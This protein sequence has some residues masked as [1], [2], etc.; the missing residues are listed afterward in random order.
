MFFVLSLLSLP[1]LFIYDNGTG[2]AKNNILRDSLFGNH[3]LGNLGQNSMQCA[4]GH[5]GGPENNIVLNLE[6]PYGNI[7]KIL[8]EIGIGM[9]AFT[10]PIRDACVV[11]ET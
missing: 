11:N 2:S 4:Y 8:P 5:F 7:T 10:L 9:N 1:I 3:T 6:C